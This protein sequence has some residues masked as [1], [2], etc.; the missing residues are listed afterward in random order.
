LVKKILILILFTLFR[1]LMKNQIGLFKLKKLP[2]CLGSGKHKICPAH[3]EASPALLSLPP[4]LLYLQ[5]SQSR[6]NSVG[7]M[8]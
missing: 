4:H 8:M 2:R 1:I 5:L 7:P 6:A 3:L